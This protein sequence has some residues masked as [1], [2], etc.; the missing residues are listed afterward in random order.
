MFASKF[1]DVV[2]YYVLRDE[3]DASMRGY[4][5]IK[6]WI[7]NPKVGKAFSCNGFSHCVEDVL[8]G[9]GSVW[10]FLHFLELGLCVI[11]W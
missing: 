8:V 2:C 11:K 9:K 6:G 1:F 4:S 5:E 3:G 10:K 7:S